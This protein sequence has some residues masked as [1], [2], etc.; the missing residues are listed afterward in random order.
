MQFS[1]GVRNAQLDAIETTISTGAIL[2]IRS[3][4]APANVAAADAGTVS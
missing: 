1:A 2:K 3:G 4:A